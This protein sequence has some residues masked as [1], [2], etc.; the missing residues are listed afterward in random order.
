MVSYFGHYILHGFSHSFL[1][2]PSEVHMVVSPFTEG[3][4]RL[5]EGGSISIQASQAVG[6]TALALLVGLLVPP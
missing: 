1:G 2:S 6:S 5:R 4:L 3:K